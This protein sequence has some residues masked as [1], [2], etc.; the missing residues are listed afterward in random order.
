M[1]M[2]VSHIHC[3]YV[4]V[5]ACVCMHVCVCV[6]RDMI[7]MQ[8]DVSHIHCI[9]VCMYA[10]MCMCTY[11]QGYVRHA[12]G[13]ESYTLYVYAR[14]RIYVYGCM[15]RYMSGMQRDVSHIHSV[16]MCV[17]IHACMCI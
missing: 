9:S 15:Y 16:C 8:R 3:M 7:G 11:V 10:C 14:V 4:C 12:A 2:D 6:N 1:Q 13:C 5:C 17:R